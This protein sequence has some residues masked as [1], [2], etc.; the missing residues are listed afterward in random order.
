M[1]YVIILAGGRGARMGNTDVPKQFIELTGVPMLVYSMRTAQ[2]NK[3]I[4]AICVVAPT[5]SH[6][7][8]R[9]WA[10][11]YGITKLEIL[12]E[13]GKERYL[14][15]YSGLTALPAKKNDTIMIMTAVC[16]FVSQ[17]TID[18]HYEV[19][20]KLDACI[21]VVKATDAITFSNDGKR[22]NRT[23]QKKKLFVQ[24]GP[25]TFRYGILRM[26][27]DA[28]LQEEERMEVNEDSELVLNLGIEVG[29]VIGDRFC[30]KVTYPEDVA[31]AEA[32][33]GLFEQKES[34][35]K[36][37]KEAEGK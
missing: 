6:D 10:K 20:E 36:Q 12:A 29:M 24:Q 15:V 7:Q 8:V 18:K 11:Q 28:Y 21:T 13:A 3:N 25:Q 33:H 2:T 19:M 32:L 16:P 22:V 26:G 9:R 4:D 5:T 35:Y 27:H 17:A 14:S 34:Q 31:I 1:N 37:I 23:L 30:I